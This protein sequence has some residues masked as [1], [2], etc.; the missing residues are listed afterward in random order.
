MHITKG[1][2]LRHVS[3]GLN[4]DER[5]EALYEFQRLKQIDALGER[6]LTHRA[7]APRRGSY[8]PLTG[9]PA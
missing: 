7:N 6:H 5:R 1:T 4:A 8:N 2:D 3:T 9:A